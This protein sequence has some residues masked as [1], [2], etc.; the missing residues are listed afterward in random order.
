MKFEKQWKERDYDVLESQMR[1]KD[2][3]DLGYEDAIHDLRIV[4]KT[5]LPM[6]TEEDSQGFIDDVM[7]TMN[8]G[9]EYQSDDFNRGFS[10]GLQRKTEQETILLEKEYEDEKER[11]IWLNPEVQYPLTIIHDRFSGSYSG[12]LFT[13]LPYEYWKIPKDGPDGSDLD[14][15]KFWK[16]FKGPVGLGADPVSAVD[17]LIK[18]MR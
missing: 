12:G 6:I 9:V 5:L 15:K 4:L 16:T 2:A 17:D 14:C 10:L 1:P 7:K 11:E 8:D 18:K 13:A 3:Y